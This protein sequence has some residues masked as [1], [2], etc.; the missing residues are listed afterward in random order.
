MKT[1][2]DNLILKEFDEKFPNLCMIE[3][4]I[5]GHKDIDVKEEVLQ[6]ILKALSQAQKEEQERQYNLLMSCLPK[7]AENLSTL[8]NDQAKRLIDCFIKKNP[9][10]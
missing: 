8:T 7:D 10:S 3:V 4:I 6:S 9:W 1:K 2:L 5:D